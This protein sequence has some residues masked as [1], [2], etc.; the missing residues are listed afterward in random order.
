MHRCHQFWKALQDSQ[1]E[2]WVSIDDDVEVSLQT[3]QWMLQAIEGCDPRI[4]IVPCLL[5]NSQ[6]VNIDFAKLVIERALPDGGMVRRC[7]WGGF[8]LV[9][10]NRH[11]MQI[12]ADTAPQFRDDDGVMK[13]APFYEILENGRWYGEDISFFERVAH[14]ENRITVE[15]LIT[16]ESIHGGQRLDLSVLRSV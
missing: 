12:V 10:M 4:V 16:G 3:A 1:S 5:R 8:G 6:T 11:A 7:T 15:A 2:A 13:P 9:A 14:L